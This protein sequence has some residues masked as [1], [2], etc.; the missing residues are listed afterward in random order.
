[1][2]KI[3]L[4][5][6]IVSII[7]VNLLVACGGQP[8]PTTPQLAESMPTEVASAEAI[9]STT[10]FNA[11]DFYQGF[12]AR[13]HGANRSGRRGPALLPER[14][15]QADEYYFEIIKNGGPGGMPAWGSQLTDEEITALIAFLRTAPK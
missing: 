13:C 7:L 1:M 10:P 8:T 3:R 2:R 11:A 12:C 4:M 9:S 6:P 15:T 14:L 5:I